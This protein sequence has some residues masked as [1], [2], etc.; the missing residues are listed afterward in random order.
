MFEN[1]TLLL[2]IIVL[3]VAVI[4]GFIVI[5]ILMDDSPSG[6]AETSAVLDAVQMQPAA[7]PVIC[8]VSL[9]AT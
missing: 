7:A 6:S 3:I 9:A 8:S 5:S 4:V 2:V 1:Q